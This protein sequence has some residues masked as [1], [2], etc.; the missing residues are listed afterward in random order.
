MFTCHKGLVISWQG[1]MLVWFPTIGTTNYPSNMWMRHPETA[2]QLHFC[3]VLFP[4]L[5]FLFIVC[6][7]LYNIRSFYSGWEY[8]LSQN[9]PNIPMV[10][11]LSSAIKVTVLGPFISPHSEM[12]QELLSPNWLQHL[13][14]KT[15]GCYYTFNRDPVMCSCL[16]LK[17]AGFLLG[18]VPW[19]NPMNSNEHL[20][21]S[22]NR[23][24][25]AYHISKIIIDYPSKTK[26]GQGSSPARNISIYVPF[27][28]AI[29]LK[30][31]LIILVPFNSLWN[32]GASCLMLQRGR[33]VSGTS[34]VV[35]CWVASKVTTMKST[36]STPP[37]SGSWRARRMAPRRNGAWNL[38]GWRILDEL[39]VLFRVQWLNYHELVVVWVRGLDPRLGGSC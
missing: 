28:W 18:L 24:Y 21:W 4:K 20:S 32:Q 17:M 13:L 37:R 23:I 25:Y 6:I 1:S 7:C 5:S 10:C 31:P 3:A 33:C 30:M 16:L 8:G 14:Q 38:G 19:T 12:P 39:G 9:T 35:N 36:R 34:A 2:R 29:S 27:F 22:P 11:H 26:D 15:S